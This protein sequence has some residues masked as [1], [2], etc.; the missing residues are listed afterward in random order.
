[1]EN[2]KQVPGWNAVDG[3][4]PG[5]TIGCVMHVVHEINKFIRE[6]YGMH[7]VIDRDSDMIISRAGSVNPSVTFTISFI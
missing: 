7:V 5:K 6:N 2:E 4:E 3:G 1:M